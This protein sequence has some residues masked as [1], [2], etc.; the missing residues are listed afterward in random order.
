MGGRSEGHIT[1]AVNMEPA[2]EPP[3]NR[4]MSHFYA[5]GLSFKKVFSGVLMSFRVV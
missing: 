4:D 1:W 2:A 5:Y 3:Y